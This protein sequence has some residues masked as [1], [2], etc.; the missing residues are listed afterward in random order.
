MFVH[1]C[2]ISLLYA[3]MD[4][5]LAKEVLQYLQDSMLPHQDEVLQQYWLPRNENRK[6]LDVK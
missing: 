5:D 2:V 6:A 1:R 3:E 4:E